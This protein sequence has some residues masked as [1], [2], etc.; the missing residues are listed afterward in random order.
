[1]GQ[2]DGKRAI[3]TGAASGIGKAIAE[4]YAAE[5]ARVA[6]LDRD[7][8]RAKEV[9]AEIGGGAFALKVDVAKEASVN[10]AVAQAIEKLGGVDVM[11][12]NAGIAT[13]A[14]AVDMPLKVWQEMIDIDLTSV[15]LGCRAVLPTMIAQKSGRIINTGSQLGFCG[16]PGLSHYCAA[17]GGVHAL[18]KSIA[19]EVAQYGINV[20]AIAPGPTST[21]MLE[22]IAPPALKAIK[23]DT[24]LKRFGRPEEIA[25][26][27][28][29]LASDKGGGYYTGA[30]MNVSGGHVMQ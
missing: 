23:D 24:A 15:F 21:P 19:R 6:V 20:N 4:H 16:A 2:L 12:N 1:M 29:L 7:L 11:V 9:A 30:V 27:A 3:V 10:K 18:T 5:G 22:D 8:P 13:S 26:T 17:K 28:V 14:F 25:P